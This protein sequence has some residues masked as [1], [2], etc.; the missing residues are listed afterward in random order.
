VLG[1]IQKGHFFLRLAIIKRVMITEVLKL[2]K[3]LFTQKEKEKHAVYIGGSK[4]GFKNSTEFTMRNKMV[5]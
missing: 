5:M 1:D 4:R 3:N 2:K